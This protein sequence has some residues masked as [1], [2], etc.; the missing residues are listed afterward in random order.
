M[1]YWDNIRLAAKE[2]QGVLEEDRPTT[3]ARVAIVLTAL[4]KDPGDVEGYDLL[5]HLDQQK[6]VEA[7]GVNGPIWALIASKSTGRTLEHESEYIQFILDQ[8]KGD[9]S[10]TF[11]GKTSDVDIT[12]M[13][14]QAL[15]PYEE[16]EEAVSSAREWL[17][18][19]QGPDGDYGN[20]ESTAQVI[21]ALSCLGEDPAG[22]EDFVK[23]GK[24]LTDGLMK[25]RRDGGFSH[26]DEDVTNGMSTEQA[27]LA[28]D[29][30]ELIK[31][32]QSLY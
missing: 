22:A 1:T 11:D 21:I 17:A 5:E 20:C 12:A 8:Q 9:G 18:G 15:A 19:K 30:A 2:G 7:Q 25:Y 29:A 14:I 10:F 32:G 31:K 13:A 23:E 24:S 4:G 16:A 26:E 27:L 3:N 6:P 28:L